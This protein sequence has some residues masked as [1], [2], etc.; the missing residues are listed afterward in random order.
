MSLIDSQR[1]GP[2]KHN[3]KLREFVLDKL[4]SSEA[5]AISAIA[6]GDDPVPARL[7]WGN[8]NAIK[9]LDREGAVDVACLSGALAA[10]HHQILSPAQLGLAVVTYCGASTTPAKLGEFIQLIL[11]STVFNLE[12]IDESRASPNEF[13]M[14][15]GGPVCADHIH[16]SE[17]PGS[18]DERSDVCSEDASS[19]VA[20][21]DQQSDGAASSRGRPW[22]FNAA[23]KPAVTPTG[24]T[25]EFGGMEGRW[26]VV[27]GK[28]TFEEGRWV[29]VGGKRAWMKRLRGG[30]E[31][32]QKRGRRGRAESEDADSETETEKEVRGEKGVRGEPA[33]TP[34]HAART[35][36]PSESASAA[37]APSAPAPGAAAARS[38]VAPRPGAPHVPF[39]P[40]FF[41]FTSNFWLCSV[42]R[43]GCLDR[44]LY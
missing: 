6:L 36:A 14:S 7:K 34:V 5:L 43:P 17:A 38:P 11:I 41:V 35:A 12:K 31:G 44:F 25:V 20:T 37:A 21:D 18:G 3:L 32:G 30:K 42:N 22:K 26:M 40:R 9:K 23:G 24:Q 27:K 2:L 19:D 33:V 28:M 1:D 13:A 29:D 8:E 39:A 4:C 15:S 10:Q 16:G